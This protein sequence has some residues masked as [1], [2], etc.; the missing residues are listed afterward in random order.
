MADITKVLKYITLDLY[1]KLAAKVSD[2]IKN[3]ELTPGPRGEKGDPGPQGTKGET[4]PTGPQGPAGAK[5]DTGDRG[6]QGY[7]FT[8]KV[9]ASGNLSWTNNGGLNNPS[10]V[11]IKGPQGATGAQGPMGPK[12]PQGDN[13][14]DGSPGRNGID[15]GFGSVTAKMGNTLTGTP[16]V[17][18]STSGDNSAKNFAFTFSNLKGAA[19][20]QG[21]AGPKGETGPTGPQGPTGP[22]GATGPKGA[23]GAQGPTGPQGPRG[24][25]AATKVVGTQKSG[26]T[27]ADC[28]YLCDGTD[29]QV[30]IQNAINALSSSSGGKIVILEGT[31]NTTADIVINK[32]GVAVEGMGHYNTVIKRSNGGTSSSVFN[33]TGSHTDIR[34]LYIDS[35]S[36]GTDIGIY[37]HGGTYSSVENCLL[38]SDFSYGIN[39]TQTGD[40]YHRIINT[41]M[42][43]PD[44]GIHINARRCIVTGCFVAGTFSR[45]ISI[46]GSYNLV[47]NN[48]IAQT[49]Y[50]SS[51]HSIY[52]NSG[53][54]YNL[55]AG[56]YI[57]GKNYTN[58]GGATNTF[59][60]NKYS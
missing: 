43:L 37:I 9:D 50:S 2:K 30:E 11:N 36:S 44:T 52:V 47:C 57:Y 5:G 17:S 1:D 8:P 7:T 39:I 33:I 23:T 48:Y 25:G 53:A 49:S 19:G 35:F 42:Y 16:T 28:D 46:E 56:N 59:A 22:T 45:S 31:Y 18:V 41:R 13:G 51:Q 21:P 38:G 55:V 60:D 15:A 40:G 6:P 3:V 32:L 24:R 58:N 34:N 26:H 12:G 29:D 4:G 20:A 14:Y 10:T 54:S 27:A